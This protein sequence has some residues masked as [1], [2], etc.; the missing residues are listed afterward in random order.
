LLIIWGYAVLNHENPV[1]QTT[2][3]LLSYPDV[4]MATVAVGLL[5]AVGVASAR[6]ARRRMSYE[7]WHFIH[8]YTYIAIA[9]SFSHEFSTGADFRDQRARVLWSAMY[10]LVALLLLWFRLASPIVAAFRHQLRVVAVRVEGPGVRSVYIA[11]RGLA[12]LRAEPGQ[13]FRWRFLTKDL[14]WAANPY[15]LSAAPNDTMMRV[16]VKL[17]GNHS[18]A[19]AQLA[20]GTRVIAEGPYGAFTA[21]RRT[22]RKVLFIGVGIGITPLRALLESVPGRPGD[23]TLLYRARTPADLV[24]RGEIEQIAQARGAKVHYLVGNRRHGNNDVLSTERLKQIV[25]DMAMHDVYVCGPED[26]MTTLRPSLR[27]AGVA[28]RHIHYESFTF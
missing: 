16:T 13:F 1:H 9:L 10:I 7:T 26:L 23:I 8:L 6:A 19:L 11:G 5:V 14:W 24:L 12:R 18:A 25:P 21:A 15:S 3:L 17:A 20:P 2:S 4:L 22:R 28:N 27:R